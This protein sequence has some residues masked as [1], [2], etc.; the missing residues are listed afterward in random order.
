MRRLACFVGAV[1]V[2]DGCSN[3]I[4][5]PGASDDSS[6]MVAYNADSAGLYGSLYHYPAADHA[7]G[8]MRDIYDWDSG[9]Y[10]G[11]I[12]EVSH[13][14][15]V[16]GN[17]NEFG[18][19]IGE[20]TYGGIGELQTQTGAKIDYGSLIWVTLQRAR[21]AREAIKVLGELMSTYGYASEGE[22][23]SI[24]DPQ[25]AWWES[26]SYYLPPLT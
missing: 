7:D 16:V 23:F 8:T 25:E 5:S 26:I 1:A 21:N 12:K 17:I 19:S 4:V 20:T 11:Q 2:V 18:L 24:A 22:S 14:Y 3:I 6:S 10:L 15:N 9:V 13:T